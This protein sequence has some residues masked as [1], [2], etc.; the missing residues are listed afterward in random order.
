MRSKLSDFLTRDFSAACLGHV[1]RVGSGRGQHDHCFQNMGFLLP[2]NHMKSRASTLQAERVCVHPNHDL[3]STDAGFP[4]GQN[5]D[6][7]R[8]VKPETVTRQWNYESLRGCLEGFPGIHGVVEMWLSH[9]LGKSIECFQTSAR[10]QLL[11]EG[12]LFCYS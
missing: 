8:K 3:N 4:G 6:L 2:P 11:S 5:R 10:L 7:V 1:L 12:L 9:V